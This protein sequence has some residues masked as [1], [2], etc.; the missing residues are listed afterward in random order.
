[1]TGFGRSSQALAGRDYT[2]EMRA[3]NHRYLDVRVKLPKALAMGETIVKEL[4]GGTLERGRVEIAV[5]GVGFDDSQMTEFVIDTALAEALV[6]SHR[7]LAEQLDV[8]LRLDTRVLTSYPGVLKATTS[9]LDDAEVRSF[10]Q[11]LVTPALEQLVEMR[12][13]EGASLAE[14]LV[15]HLAVLRTHCK[16]VAEAAPLMAERYRTRLESRIKEMLDGN[17]VALDEGRIL[18]EV[19]VFAEKADVE[20]ELARLDAHFEHFER[21]VDADEGEAV[22]RRLDFLCQEILRETNTIGSKA[23]A[24]ELTECVVAMKAELERLREQVQNVE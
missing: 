7:G 12:T 4:A 21:L 24:I 1:M 13:R 5:Q 23:Q 22:G 10:L 8:P 20:E 15:G 11:A 16:T 18:H 9:A 14:T 2:V 6:R 19:G 3:V 17:R